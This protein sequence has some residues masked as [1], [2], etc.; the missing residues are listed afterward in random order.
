MVS[1]RLD[2]LKRRKISRINQSADKRTLRKFAYRFFLNGQILL[3]KYYDG[4]LLRCVDEANKTMIEI[5]EGQCGPHMSG[6][7][8]AQKIL[9]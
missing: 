9:R 4:I 5:H 6:F 8:L 7:M 1:R 2:I 3:I